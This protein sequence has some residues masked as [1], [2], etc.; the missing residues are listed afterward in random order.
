MGSGQARERILDAA[1]DLFAAD[2]FDATPT[3]RIAR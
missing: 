2:G 3:A 1:E